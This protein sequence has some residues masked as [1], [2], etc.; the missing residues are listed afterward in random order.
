MV[1]LGPLDL[2]RS[3]TIVPCDCMKRDLFCPMVNR[4]FRLLD[5]A[6]NLGRYNSSHEGP[7][8]IHLIK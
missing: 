8:L 1:Q 4:H 5:D 7:R 2:H 6:S 3:S